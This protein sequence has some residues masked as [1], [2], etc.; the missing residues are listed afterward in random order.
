M[1]FKEKLREMNPSRD[2]ASLDADVALLCPADLGLEKDTPKTCPNFQNAAA[3]LKACEDC[4]NREA[5][6][7]GG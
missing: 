6:D 2:E 7:D 4:W 3:A 5:P 1:T